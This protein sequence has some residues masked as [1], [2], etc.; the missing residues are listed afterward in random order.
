MSS[1]LQPGPAHPSA[2]AELEASLE[3]SLP[4]PT[5]APSGHE[6]S[7]P[8]KA[9]LLPLTPPKVSPHVRGLDAPLAFG[10]LTVRKGQV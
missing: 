6:V 9:C 2:C 5:W 1:A 10:A 8:V 4:D 3:C 7:E